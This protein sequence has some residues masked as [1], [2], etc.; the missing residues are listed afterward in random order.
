MAHQLEFDAGDI[1]NEL[2]R[3]GLPALHDAWKRIACNGFC[4]MDYEVGRWVYTCVGK[5]V[6]PDSAKHNIGLD[7]IVPLLKDPSHR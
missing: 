3:C 1:L 7:R 6:G 4:T 2:A 5:E